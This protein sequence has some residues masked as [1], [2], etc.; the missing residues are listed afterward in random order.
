MRSLIRAIVRWSLVE[1]IVVNAIGVRCLRVRA[2][3]R[4]VPARR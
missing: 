1:L 2:R 3:S 4:T